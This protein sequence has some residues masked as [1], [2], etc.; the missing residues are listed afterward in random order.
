MS[1]TLKKFISEFPTD[2]F[3]ALTEEPEDRGGSWLDSP[4][5]SPFIVFELLEVV[6][7]EYKDLDQKYLFIDNKST[8]ERYFKTPHGILRV[9]DYKGGCSIGYSG[10]L[11]PELKSD[12]IFFKKVLQDQ[13]KK[14]SLIKSKITKERIK[15]NPLINFMRTFLA[16]SNL[17]KKAKENGSHVEA[18]VLFA[19]QVD[20][21]LRFGMILK[22]QIRDNTKSYDSS[23]IFQKG[24]KFKMERTIFQDSLDIKLITKSEFNELSK[25]YDFRNCVVHRYFI[26]DLEYS[27]IPEYLNRYEKIIK[28][29]GDK[30]ELLEQEQVKKG[31]GMTNPEQLVLDE[32]TVR[33]IMREEHMK[34][35]SKKYVTVVPKRKRLFPEDEDY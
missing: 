27:K 5:L 32:K 20:A 29:L 1:K 4:S 8:W 19:S 28:K 18:L 11:T 21:M 3:I 35:D 16:V 13:W 23:L 9:Y 30:L 26:S 7:G 31:V 2:Q 34:I 12:A 33:F 6:Y 14:Y 24:K 17:L 10:V 25:L 15:E 22:M